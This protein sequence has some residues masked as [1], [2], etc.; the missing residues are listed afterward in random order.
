MIDGI[1][2][3]L[4]NLVQSA[5][6]NTQA[7]IEVTVHGNATISVKHPDNV[8]TENTIR[9]A[10]IA[11]GFLSEDGTVSFDGND[12]RYPNGYRIVVKHNHGNN[13]VDVEAL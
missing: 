6:T 10:L 2:G 11:N 9:S 7:T 5:S 4:D 8:L 1:S 3:V 12:V 13:R